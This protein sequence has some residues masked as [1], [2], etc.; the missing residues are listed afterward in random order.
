[1]EISPEK[2]LNNCTSYQLQHILG[3]EEI[4]F[5]GYFILLNSTV[6]SKNL[7]YKKK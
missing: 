3:E 6:F 7:G 4:D 2:S 1:M 5:Q